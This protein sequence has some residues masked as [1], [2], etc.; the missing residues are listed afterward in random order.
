MDSVFASILLPGVYFCLFVFVFV[1]LV[2]LNGEKGPFMLRD[3][4]D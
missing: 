3:T 1:L 2:F 4:N